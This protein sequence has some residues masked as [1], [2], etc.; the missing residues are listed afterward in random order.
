MI[1][2]TDN[3][4][5]PEAIEEIKQSAIAGGFG[6]WSPPTA[7][8][9]T[10]K[11]EGMAW[12]AK[13]HI[14]HHAISEILGRAIYP[15]SS[16]VRVT[17]EGME[18]RYIHSDRNDGDFT[19]ITYLTDH[20][21]TRSGTEFFRHIPTGATEMPLACEISEQLVDDMVNGEEDVWEMTDSIKGV[22]GRMLIFSAPLF[23][24]R[25]PIHGIG[26]SPENGRIVHACHFY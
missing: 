26:D 6:T 10:G 19:A 9:G 25:F 14:I 23:H 2:V 15:K 24:A 16:F 3:F 8:V 7:K 13:H 21:D 18:K 11:Y 1:L 22:I 5:K 12:H 17:N 20:G 4:F